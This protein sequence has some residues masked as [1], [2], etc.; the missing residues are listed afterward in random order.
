MKIGD[1]L[2]FFRIQQ[3]KTQ[4]ELASGVISISY[5]SKI[6]NNQ[7]LPSLEVVD[8]LCERLGIRFLDEEEPML[9]DELKDWYKL[10]ISGEKEELNNLYPEIKDQMDRAKDSTTLVYFMLFE[11]RYFLQ[12]RR[13][14]EARKSLEKIH[15]I[16]DIFTEELNYYL[17][18]FAGLSNY[19]HEK[20]ND[21]YDCYKKA[22]SIMLRTVLEK[23]EEADLYYSLGL[24]TSQLWKSTL[25]I[26]YTNQALA[27]YQA[28]YNYK[29]SAEC[30]IL[31]GISYR[32]SDEL[33]KAEDS[34]LLADKIAN[35]LN[36][37]N[38]K[39]FIHHNLGYL[40]SMQG[41]SDGAI[42]HYEKSILFHE[43]VNYKQ[44][45]PT[46]HSIISE[47]YKK[48]DYK[49]GLDW[50]RKGLKNLENSDNECIEF[51]YHFKTY[52]YLMTTHTIEFEEFLKGK[53]IPYFTEQNK[54][55]FVA[56]YS[57]ILAKYYEKTFKYKLSSQYLKISIQALKKINNI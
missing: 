4:D 6:E 15:E 11:V 30:Q 42:K 2:R 46:I 57:E 12:V 8:R 10:I 41:K 36:N 14:D 13:L 54:S 27:I 18:K 9:L 56:D 37:S 19:I 21:A 44:T 39:G 16:A 28:H 53:V 33:S 34:Y 3:N 45:F 24:T 55:L 23:W 51:Y 29:R 25:C 38:L 32:R 20:Y 52:Q 50:V 26:N 43:E 35:T 48:G 47:H 31:L 5:L 17:F 7:S 49:N 1:R 40:Y 22:E